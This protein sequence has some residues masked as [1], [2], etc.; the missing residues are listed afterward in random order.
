VTSLGRGHDGGGPKLGAITPLYAA[1]EVFQGKISPRSDQYSLAI[2][3]Q[4]LLTGTLPFQAKNSRKLLLLHAQAQPDLRALSEE[5]REV[6]GRALAK[7][8]EQRFPSCTALVEALEGT[9][10]G[11]TT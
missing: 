10:A 4:E 6:I 5:D 9:P 3:Y 2:A 8:P 7:D 11:D 1:P